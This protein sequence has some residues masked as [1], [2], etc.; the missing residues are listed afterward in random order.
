MREAVFHDTFGELPEPGDESYAVVDARGVL[1]SWSPG[2][3]RLLGYTVDEVQGRSATELL[4]SHAEVANLTG[5]FRAQDTAFL[6]QV[7]L[8]HRHGGRLR[9]AIWAH[10]LTGASGQ[11]CWLVHAESTD[12]FRR[13]N[14]G[15]AILGS[16]FNE[17]PFI[18]DVFDTRL[19]FV[20][21]NRR[22]RQG[23]GFPD[24]D[25]FGRTMREIAPAGLLDLT[26]FEAR[27]RQVLATGVA[28]VATEV[29]G[30][31]PADPDRDRTWSETILPLR[32]RS[33]E[34]IGIVHAVFDVTERVRAQE[35]LALVNDASSKIGGSLDVLDTAQELTDLAVPAFAD[36]AY[37]NLLDPV[38]GGEEPTAGPIADAVPLRRAAS[39]SVLGGP[40]Q[41]AVATGDV[42]PFTSGPSSLFTRAMASGEPV[43]LTG[44]EVLAELTAFDP[45]RAALVGELGVHSWL[46]VPM[47]ARGAAL[48]T[49]VFVRFQRAHQFEADDVL[50]AQ[51][52]VARAAVCIDNARRY[53]RERTTAL[54][55]QRSL[56]PRRLPTLGAVE[57]ASRYLPAGGH[58][59]LGGAWFDVIPLSGARV[60]LAVGDV[61]GHGLHSAVTMGRL[62]TAMRTLADLDLPPEEVLT[63]LDDQ[64]NRFQDES[65]ESD[66]VDESGEGLTGGAAGTTCLYAV[67]DPISRRCTM[68]RAGHPSPARVSADGRVEFLELP[69]GPAL[70]GSGAPFESG[71]L[72]LADGDLLVLYT[73]ALLKSP[74]Q[75]T[76]SRAER[77]REVLSGQPLSDQPLSGQ[78]VSG[79][80]VSG[81]AL[82]DVCE[83]VIRQM[84][85]IHPQDDVAL[86]VARVHGLDADRHVTWELASE[87]EIV[88]EAR[89]L[90]ARQLAEW[91]LADRVDLAFTTELVVS[92]LV[93]NAIRYGKPPI[94][95]T[96]I[97]DRTLVCEVTDG[98]STS[99][100]I[101]RALETDEG[102]RGLYMIAQFTQLW[103]ARYHARGKTI[104]A[105]LPLPE[106]PGAPERPSRTAPGLDP[107]IRKL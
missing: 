76:A 88:R 41:V 47:A 14:L 11:P 57:A 105:E 58:L 87:P 77:L 100:H 46:L 30:R 35:R 104:W 93:T 33:G 107:S 81:L 97:R 72:T 92:E 17:S 84:L 86:L 70:G 9:V 25:S 106:S 71:E 45:R 74:E 55:L 18:V 36:H 32:N 99:P 34:V 60:A 89:T 24:Q 85:P 62:R 10:P 42:D 68:A 4:D 61:G 101:R 73:G 43:L 91:D 95:L 103:G 79:Q 27:Q 90:T 31:V 7:V 39:S 37:V 51:E 56:L 96:L 54:A 50:L 2:A 23:A 98:S 13:R 83:A 44:P 78:P 49:V 80:P 26:A 3:E 12:D 6:G 28:M 52:F 69:G 67:F 1:M 20:A 16:L 15:R 63:H 29:R 5:R 19:R 65:D 59:E 53:T 75:G 82:D 38:F 40:G 102:G 48:G 94:R 21:Q 22:A 8:R 64:V 66:D